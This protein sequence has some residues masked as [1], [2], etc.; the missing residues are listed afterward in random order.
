VVTDDVEGGRI[1]TR[2]LTSLGH[3]VI[4]FIGD[5]PGNP[6]GFRSSRSREQGYEDV[7][8]AAGLDAGRALRRYAPHDR[9]AAA[10]VARDLLSAGPRRPT[11]I[12]ASSDVQAMGVLAA[13][14]DLGLRVPGDLSVIGFDDIELS[15][16]LHLST[17]RQPLFESGRLGVE[18]LLAALA[19]RDLPPRRR[20]LRLELVERSTTGPIR[21][22]SKR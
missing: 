19:D 22:R 11:A 10:A 7:L 20:E 5:D 9:V 6:L 14:G 8:E 17:V 18:L 15:E 2:L 13:A 21:A 4:G 12:F 16:H 1:A 3:Q